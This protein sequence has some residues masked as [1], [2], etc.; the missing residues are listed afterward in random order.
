ML[1]WILAVLAI[2][3]GYLANDLGPGGR[4]AMLIVILVAA[5]A[6]PFL[7]A[8]RHR[9]PPVAAAR[10]PGYVPAARKYIRAIHGLV[11]FSH[12]AGIIVVTLALVVRL[13]VVPASFDERALQG[14]P[15][16]L[17]V[18]AFLLATAVQFRHRDQAPLV[19]NWATRANAV[20]LAALALVT[21]VALGLTANGPRLVAGWMLQRLDAEVLLLGALLGAGT[22]LFL[23]AG[24]P[25]VL[26]IFGGIRGLFGA[27]AEP[28]SRSGT[29]PFVYGLAIAVLATLV[30]VYLTSS[31]RLLDALGNFGDSRAAALI[32]AFPLGVAVFLGV[33]AYQIYRES[34]RGL[35]RTRME[36]TRRQEVVLYAFCATM[37][38]LFAA[39]LA[40]NFSGRLA[41]FLPAALRPSLDKDLIMAGILFT[42][43]PVGWHAQRQNRLQR[44]IEDR[45]PDFLND[46]AETRRAGLT[47]TA[48][49]QSVAMSDYGPLTPELK[50]MS[51]QVAWGVPFNDALIKFAQRIHSRNVE[52][53]VYLIVEASKSGGAVSDVLSA[54]AR[55]AQELQALAQE[56]RVGMSTYLI[57]IYVVFGV[58]LAVL[59][60][61]DGAFIS[62]AIAAQKLLDT[63]GAVSGDF[64]V[65]SGHLDG[66]RMRFAYFLSGVVQSIGNGLVAGVLVEG[67][68]KGGL[69][70]AA[71]MTF[72]TWLVLRVALGG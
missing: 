57:V 68:V 51:D 49:L 16:A 35:F 21:A 67:R 36:K 30:C 1:A 10:G 20:L 54:A 24:L 22:Q 65:A 11:M 23:Q 62:K 28:E 70:H 60:V 32:V 46:L 13:R 12:L 61:L 53:T 37:G 3:A 40:L 55:D 9:V 69:K 14:F 72:L 48:A 25:T 33:S 45:L 44:G 50:K 42:A 5:L 63:T 58:F 29:P 52:R 7:L 47:L 26:E 27:R 39:L 8:R 15:L 6:Q 38:L 4:V 56:R 66:A 31:L 18:Y 43:G 59:A 17:G 19:R 34:R 2:V 64:A 71:I 41:P